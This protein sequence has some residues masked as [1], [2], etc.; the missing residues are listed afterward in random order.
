MP[1]KRNR[2]PFNDFGKDV[3]AAREAM[4]ETQKN[5]AGVIGIDPRYLANIENSGALP[6]LPIFYELV[7]HCKLSVDRYFHPNAA[8]ARES[9]ERERIT[10]KLSV[11]PDRYLQII[12][13]TIDAAINLA[14]AEEQGE[15]FDVK[16]ALSS[17]MARLLKH[18]ENYQRTKPE[19]DGLLL[20]KDKA[21]YRREHESAILLHEVAARALQKY[22]GLSGRLPNPAPLQAEYARLTEKKNALRAEYGNL[23]RQARDLGVVKRNVD[24]ILNPGTERTLRKD[25]D[26]AL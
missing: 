4:K 24:I 17:E 9:K 13:G 22:A 20:A 7:K 15:S 11:C 12:E 16:S 26:M 25:K 19:Y 3:K 1:R 5:L 10:L 23:K 18:I 8:E 21:A 6:S 14:E 2:E